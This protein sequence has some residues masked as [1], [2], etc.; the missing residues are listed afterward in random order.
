MLWIEIWEI[1]A[2]LL[3]SYNYCI[4]ITVTDTCE[5][6]HFIHDLPTCSLSCVRVYENI[7]ILYQSVRHWLELTLSAY[8]ENYIQERGVRY[9][10][11]QNKSSNIVP[12]LFSIFLCWTIV[13]LLGITCS[14]IICESD[15]RHPISRASQ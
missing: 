15:W 1:M 10:S 9:F 11:A 6:I 2:A 13:S 14:I 12:C 5:I 4:Y 7:T 8:R 3:Y